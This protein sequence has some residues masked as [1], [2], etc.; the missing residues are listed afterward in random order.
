MILSEYAAKREELEKKLQEIGEL[1]AE[2]KMEMSVKHQMQLQKIA[3]Q[4][5]ALKHQRA[6]LN[7]QYEID[8]SWF[9]KKCREE[10]QVIIQKIHLLRM[11][12]LTFVNPTPPQFYRRAA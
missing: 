5:G 4:I 8:K 11:E 1:Q 2:H 3:K 12:Y 6:E 7:K 9:K 10:K